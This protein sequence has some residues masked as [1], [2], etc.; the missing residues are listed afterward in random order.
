M[1]PRSVHDNLM[2]LFMSTLLSQALDNCTAYV[3]IKGSTK[4]P[5]LLTFSANTGEGLMTSFKSLSV[6]F[7]SLN[8]DTLK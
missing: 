4:L 1:W 2:T 3:F 8:L 5:P 7:V 6:I